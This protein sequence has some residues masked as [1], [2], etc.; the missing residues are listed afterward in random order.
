MQ[1]PTAVGTTCL[2]PSWP[3][4][5]QVGAGIGSRKLP[6]FLVLP[7]RHRDSQSL[8]Q[9]ARPTTPR[10]PPYPHQHHAKGAA[11]PA[12]LAMNAGGNVLRNADRRPAYAVGLTR[13]SSPGETIR[14]ARRRW[15]PGAGLCNSTEHPAHY[16]GRSKAGVQAIA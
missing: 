9:S 10:S 12:G 5:G 14:I 3:V 15:P 7:W 8:G 16:L 1:G 11:P 13:P 6:P 4:L 2:R